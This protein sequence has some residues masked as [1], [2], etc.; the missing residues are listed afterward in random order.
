MKLAPDEPCRVLASGFDTVVLSI[1]ATWGGGSFFEYLDKLKAQST[2]NK[3]SPGE[4]FAHGDID[5]WMFTVRPYGLNGYAWVLD[6]GQ[7]GAEIARAP[8]PGHRPNIRV[9]SRSETLWRLGF[10]G[11]V[12]WIL[13]HIEAAGAQIERIKPSR[14]DPCVDILLRESD[15]SMDLLPLFVTRAKDRSPHLHLTTL[16][17]F[18]IGKAP[19]SVRLYDKPLEIRV[20]SNKVWMYD[21]WMLDRVPDGHRIIRVEFEILRA[22]LKRMGIDTL[23]DLARKTDSMWAYCTKWFSVQTNPGKHHTQRKVL[24]WWQVVTDGFGNAQ[25]AQPLVLD[26]ACRAQRDQLGRQLLG[27]MSS[28]VALRNQSGMIEDV[29]MYTIAQ[30]LPMLLNLSHSIGYSDEQ[31]SEAV[32]K[33]IA[34]Y[35]RSGFSAGA[36]GDDSVSSDVPI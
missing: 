28:L 14:L 33:K 23:P 17:G 16:S 12:A 21:V 24:P 31:F 2:D 4:N 30:E 26:K 36:A 10:D 1:D 29:G 5:P 3:P 13:R 20:K 34:K 19:I 6:S 15:W 27:L 25:G 35:R 11:A 9:L 8:V 32:H 7:W 22:K 18:S